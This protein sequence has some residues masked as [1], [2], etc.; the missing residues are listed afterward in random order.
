V[1]ET[2][3]P[4]ISDHAREQFTR[5]SDAPGL[6]VE[7]AWSHAHEIPGGDWLRGEAAR[8]DPVSRCVLVVRDGLLRTA[9]YAP[10]AKPPIQRA[11]RAAG[12]SP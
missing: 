9:I 6:T 7:T 3:L 2:A 8:Y 1:S 4:A 11:V 12:W 10:T 5:R